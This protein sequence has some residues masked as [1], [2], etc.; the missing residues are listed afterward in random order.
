[1]RMKKI[2]A[3]LYTVLLLLISIV[4]IFIYNGTY[5]YKALYASRST[6]NI[7]F[8]STK[9]DE[10]IVDK[11]YAISNK[12]HII[13]TRYVYVN[14]ATVQAFTTNTKSYTTKQVK[15]KDTI[16]TPL[17]DLNISVEPLK[18]MN[19][20]AGNNGIYYISTTNSKAIKK[21]ISDFN[22][23][24]MAKAKIRDRYTNNVFM[25]TL[26][27]LALF[28]TGGYIPILVLLFI[29]SF[30]ILFLIVKVAIKE[31]KNMVTIATKGF[32]PLQTIKNISYF[33]SIPLFVS[34]IVSSLCIF[35]LITIKGNAGF[36]LYFLGTNCM[37]WLILFLISVIILLF[38]IKHI[39]H[40]S[41]TKGYSSKQ[42]LLVIESVLKYIMI[43]SAFILLFFLL[44]SRK[45]VER[46]MR[47]E[48]D[49]LQT[50]NIYKMV[51]DPVSPDDK[52]NRKIDLD[53]VDMYRELESS[54]KIFMIESK[55][56][57][58]L[59]D[60]RLIW[61][62]SEDT[63]KNNIYSKRSITVDENY[64]K[65]H[66]VSTASGK[67]PLKQIVHDDTVQNILVPASMK[68]KEESIR[69]SFLKDFAFQKIETANKYHAKFKEPKAILTM[70]DLKINIIYVEDDHKYFT[71]NKDIFPESMGS[72]TNPLVIVD[73]MNVD[74][75][76]Y[77]S[78]LSNA[79]YFESNKPD[80]FP[81]IQN[82]VNKHGL[83]E[84]YH[85][86][87]S[88]Y[89]EKAEIKEFDT[90]IQ[91]DSFVITIT[92]GLYIFFI[93]LLARFYY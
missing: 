7:S 56:L 30:I 3:I 33:Y 17:P 48:E 92:V 52:V 15:G 59:S 79:V 4:H 31:S 91:L 39:H 73:T 65:K 10:E 74:P 64:L 42:S 27:Y 34:L 25:D 5:Q 29:C 26:D 23:S 53:S 68:D 8:D 89:N 49:W 18:Q 57:I 51:A 55:N 20:I 45:Q 46:T 41:I 9:T 24:H 54:G 50:E 88:I 69:A 1:M 13:T 38:T 58:S 75:N 86:V 66:P 80:G 78:Y 60:G 84:T 2:I 62:L 90:F 71:Y 67:D 70:N 81:E 37:V 63:D 43:A 22:G 6:I 72:V 93:Y 36:L 19:K 11:I 21:I 16:I 87:R 32:S 44:N 82:I 77:H 83:L 76:Y 47:N 14:D 12:H 35:L 28:I 85:S 61:Q 40:T